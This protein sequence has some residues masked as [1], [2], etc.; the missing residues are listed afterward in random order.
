MPRYG[1]LDRLAE[2]LERNFGHTG[3]AAVLKQ[4]ID[5]APTADV[6]PVVHSSWDVRV[7]GDGWNE[8]SI[9][10]CKNCGREYKDFGNESYCSHC[11]AKM[12]GKEK[13]DEN[14]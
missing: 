9:C 4:L 10:R 6:A 14:S 11:G 13:N 2:V 3:G 7:E 12:D 8:W 1:D 5:N